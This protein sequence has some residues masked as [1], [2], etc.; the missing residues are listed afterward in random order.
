MSST[1]SLSSLVNALRAAFDR[2]G[3]VGRFVS[4]SSFWPVALK[5]G[6]ENTLRDLLL[7]D[8][9]RQVQ[10][11]IGPQLMCTGERGWAGLPVRGDILVFTPS[12]ICD[13]GKVD[14]PLAVIELKANFASQLIAGPAGL[15]GLRSVDVLYQL[16]AL[17]QPSGVA[18][19]G[20]Q[21]VHEVHSD[22]EAEICLLKRYKAD[23]PSRDGRWVLPDLVHQLETAS[24]LRRSGVACSELARFTFG[25]GLPRRF[26]QLSVLALWLTDA[27]YGT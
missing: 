25:D 27:T 1:K 14:T 21:F 19:L 26:G 2:D 7:A 6:Y 23:R 17:C 20:I 12:S 15:T 8:L 13:S 10:S 24:W 16:G 4:S 3:N 5:G 9:E 18:S 22:A 11:Y